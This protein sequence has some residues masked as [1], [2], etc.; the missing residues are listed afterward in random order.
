MEWFVQYG[1]F[2]PPPLL[3]HIPF[4]P[5]WCTVDHK[6]SVCPPSCAQCI[7]SMKQLGKYQHKYCHRLENIPLPFP[8][9]KYEQYMWDETIWAPMIYFIRKMP[10]RDFKPVLNYMKRMNEVH[11][12]S[13]SR[14]IQNQMW[15]NPKKIRR[16]IRLMLLVSKSIILYYFKFILYQKLKSYLCQI[17][18]QLFTDGD[19]ISPELPKEAEIDFSSLFMNFDGV[20]CLT[21]FYWY[22]SFSPFLWGKC[23]VGPPWCGQRTTC[24]GM[25]RHM[26]GKYKD[27][28]CHKY[29]YFFN[30]YKV[31]IN[32]DQCLYKLKLP[33]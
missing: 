32:L 2:P 9:Y 15:L 27:Q 13:I 33:R 29:A 5:F 21:W 19:D 16:L 22:Y 30:P 1:F 17:N 28:N 25:N 4:L 23:S 31:N 3:L 12:I 14:M 11:R 18:K 26:V 7:L 10:P 24:D 20:N 6:Y 8:A